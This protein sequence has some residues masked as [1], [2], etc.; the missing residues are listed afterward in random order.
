MIKGSKLLHK[1]RIDS[2]PEDIVDLLH[3]EEENG[4]V[5]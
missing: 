5:V 2:K 1:L 3:Y 4:Q